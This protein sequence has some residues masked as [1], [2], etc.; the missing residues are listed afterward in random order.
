MQRR[1]M[2]EYSAQRPALAA[3]EQAMARFSPSIL[4]KDDRF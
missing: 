3:F 4:S 2:Q 1:R